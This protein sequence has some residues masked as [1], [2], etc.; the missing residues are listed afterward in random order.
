[1]WVAGILALLVVAVAG[2]LPKSEV[3]TLVA[4]YQSTHGPEWTQQWPV[5]DLETACQWFGVFC[6]ADDAYVRG[7]SLAHNNLRGNLLPFS[8]PN[9]SFL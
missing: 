9:L 4:L 1:M 2:A 5:E 7:L 3:D 6:A 8:F